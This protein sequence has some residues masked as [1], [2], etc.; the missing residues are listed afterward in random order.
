[1]RANKA[2]KV[3]VLLLVAATNK[4]YLIEPRTS[5]GRAKQLADFMQGKG[6]FPLFW[7]PD[8]EYPDHW[9]CEGGAF[10]LLMVNHNEPGNGLMIFRA[11]IDWRELSKRSMC[12]AKIGG[13]AFPWPAYVPYPD[14]WKFYFLNGDDDRIEMTGPVAREWFIASNV[15]TSS[16]L[17]N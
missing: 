11:G 12:M 14:H 10:D 4:V 3:D 1:M 8:R 9:D 17:N 16:A 7:D 13:A 15:K 5:I 2:E 6:L